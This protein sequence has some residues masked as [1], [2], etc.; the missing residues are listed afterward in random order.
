MCN[1]IMGFLDFRKKG[2]V[3]FLFVLCMLV[4]LIVTDSITF[5]T[6]YQSTQ[7]KTRHKMESYA[8]AVEYSMTNR[9]ENTVGWARK[10]YLNKNIEGF[11]EQDFHS[12]LGYVI[13]RQ[14]FMKDTL[15][16]NMADDIARMN[17]YADNDGIVNGGMFGRIETIK[18]SKWYKHLQETG[19]NEMLFLYYDDSQYAESEKKRKFVFIKKLNYFLRGKEKIL[20]LELDYRDMTESLKKLN[21]DLPVYV[22]SG[23]TILISNKIKSSMG[24]QLEQFTDWDKIG[25]QKTLHL[26]GLDIRIF[27][28]KECR[29]RIEDLIQYLPI[30]IVL[31]LVNLIFPIVLVS[32]LNRNKLKEREMKLARTRAELLALQSQIN[33]HFLFNALE[34]I[35]MHSILKNEYETASMVEKLAVME[36]KNVEWGDDSVEIEQ[37]IDFVKAYLGLQKY[38]FG[39]RLS[40]ELDVDAS[41]I[42]YKVPKLSIVT[43]VENACVHGIESKTV[44]GWIFVRVYEEK[45]KLCIEIEDTGCGMDEIYMEKLRYKMEHASI[46]SLKEKGRVGMINACL[47]LKMISNNEVEF[48]LDGEKGMGTMILIRIPRNYVSKN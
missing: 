32:A 39:E 48:E 18:D 6:I 27:V 15:L 44:P 37:E 2:K 19:N 3:Q 12:P 43:F 34:S 8:S 21:Y 4:P 28:L 5:Y 16:E 14:K 22:C 30:S 7:A 13:S 33:P 17:I 42:H 31:I 9:V 24:G 41:C 10:I 1:K 47:R 23:D 29:F 46:E 35:R 11:L 20:K 38:R 45:E 40:F 36:R 26:Y 25:Y